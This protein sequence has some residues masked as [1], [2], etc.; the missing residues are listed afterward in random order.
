MF[1]ERLFAVVTQT[2]L[3]YG[4]VIAVVVWYLARS[5]AKVF[6]VSTAV[7]T[8]GELVGRVYTLLQWVPTG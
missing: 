5:T 7:A 6:Y 3:C 2:A 1:T 4:Y 8:C